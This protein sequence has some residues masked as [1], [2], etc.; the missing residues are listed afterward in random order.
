MQITVEMNR[1]ASRDTTNNGT[2]VTAQGCLPT[3]ERMAVCLFDKTAEAFTKTIF[4]M[5]PEGRDPSEMSFVGTFRGSIRIPRSGNGEYFRADSFEVLSG[6]RLELQRMVFGI[7]AAKREADAAP[8][9][10]AALAAYQ[11]LAE[12]VL[13]L[14]IPADP[15]VDFGDEAAQASP[16][17][18]AVAAELVDVSI[19]GQLPVIEEAPASTP[20]EDAET[21]GPVEAPLL[22]ED[23][24]SPQSEILDPPDQTGPARELVFDGGDAT[25]ADAQDRPEAVQAAESA[26]TA[27]PAADAASSEAVDTAEAAPAPTPEPEQVAPA[28]QAPALPPIG[29]PSLVPPSPA[30]MVPPRRP[31]MMPPP[32]PRPPIP[33]RPAPSTP[34]APPP[35]PGMGRR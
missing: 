11:A 10:E 8:T 29:R 22:A 27:G 24:L 2:M 6:P 3:G 16:P 12:R 34:P 26:E 32:P 28:P 18:A 14:N 31:G 30:G 19:S 9:A 1:F 17:V 25:A 35:P 7:G 20:D 23:V 4:S 5:V 21:S 15:D 13:G 33:P